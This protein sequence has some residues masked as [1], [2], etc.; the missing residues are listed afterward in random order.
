[1]W[2]PQVPL[3]LQL[4]S[5]S[6]MTTLLYLITPLSTFWFFTSH[7]VMMLVCCY[8]LPLLYALPFVR[9]VEAPQRS[10][11][12]DA[13]EIV[14][15][16]PLSLSYPA[17]LLSRQLYYVVYVTSFSTQTNCHELMSRP[18]LCYH[19]IHSIHISPLI[20]QHLCFIMSY[21]C[22]S[23]YINNFICRLLFPYWYYCSLINC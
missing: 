12:L 20:S 15:L 14:N 2:Q 3:L 23:F 4:P 10:F 8:L 11:Y 1:M 13:A 21:L 16:W 19:S 18:F 22:T 17:F 9:M 5:L 7:D 6:L